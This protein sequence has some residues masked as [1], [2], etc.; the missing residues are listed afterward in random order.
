MTCVAA[1][2]EWPHFKS[3][4]FHSSSVF[5]ADTDNIDFFLFV[6]ELGISK[7]GA[8]FATETQSIVY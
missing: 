1:R 5:V 8:R 3:N 7:C 6:L 4:F 2:K